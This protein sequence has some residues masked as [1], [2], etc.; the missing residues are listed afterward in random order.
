[1]WTG[2]EL[3]DGDQVQTDVIGIMVSVDIVDRCY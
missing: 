2:K 1:M 3:G